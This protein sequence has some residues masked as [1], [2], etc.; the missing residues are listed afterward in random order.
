M[1]Y[2][3]KKASSVKE[4]G[5]NIMKDEPKTQNLKH[6]VWRSKSIDYTFNHKNEQDGNAKR[7]KSVM[8]RNESRR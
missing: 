3:P 2:R 5:D 8:R 6:R 7:S 4:E 1:Q